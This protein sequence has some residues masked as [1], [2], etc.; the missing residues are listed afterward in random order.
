MNLI[1]FKQCSPWA[2]FF[3]GRAHGQPMDIDFWESYTRLGNTESLFQGQ[4]QVL[5]GLFPNQVTSDISS[6]VLM[7]KAPLSVFIT[8]KLHVFA[9]FYSERTVNHNTS[10]EHVFKPNSIS[11][12]MISPLLSL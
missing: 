10:L 11:N 8:L 2:G 5:Q 7:S 3:R 12:Y 6:L 1:G 4:Y 9:V